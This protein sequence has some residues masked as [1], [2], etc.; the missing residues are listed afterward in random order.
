VALPDQHLLCGL[1]CTDHPTLSTDAEQGNEHLA[2]RLNTGAVLFELTESE[3][4]S[5]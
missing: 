5:L 1:V 2:V 4:S 3:Q